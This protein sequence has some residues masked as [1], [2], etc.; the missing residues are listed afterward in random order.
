[1]AEKP[2]LAPGLRSAAAT[3]LYS[4]A[5]RATSWTVTGRVNDDYILSELARCPTC[6]HE[7][8]EKTLVEPLS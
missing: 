3:R 2:W 7:I 5:L 8:T 6:K 4:D 1:M